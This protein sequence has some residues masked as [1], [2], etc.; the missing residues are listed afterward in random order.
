M[1]P[2]RQETSTA[3]RLAA[4]YSSPRAHALMGSELIIQSPE[5]GSALWMNRR[6]LNRSLMQA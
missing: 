3:V 2:G 6:P 4:T 1:M 5:T